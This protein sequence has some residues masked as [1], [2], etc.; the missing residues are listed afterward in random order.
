M[1]SVLSIWKKQK[2][3]RVE[4]S[5]ET[6]LNLGN[7]IPEVPGIP[8]GI[9]DEL[10]PFEKRVLV[11]NEKKRKFRKRRKKKIKITSVYT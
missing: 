11:K 6:L 1:G 5:D 9:L 2:R 10:D 8:V 3:S 7:D 4:L